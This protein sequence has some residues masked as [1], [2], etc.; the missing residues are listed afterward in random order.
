MLNKK[1]FENIRAE[2]KEFEEKRELTIQNSRD[3][4]ALS[5]QCVYAVHRGDM[6]AAE[7]T[8]PQMKS[9]LKKLDQ[10]EDYETSMAWVAFQEYAEAFCFFELVKSK[11]IPTV[12][13]VGIPVHAYLAG[14]CDLSGEVMRKA[15]HDVIKKDYDS[16]M[17]WKDVV[18]ELYGVFLQFDLRNGELR[19]KSDQIKWNLNKLEDMV[20]T[21]KTGARI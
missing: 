11:K 14:L 17:Q 4:I 7:A 13:E 12:K 16:V 6:K 5:K 10:A 9:L 15:V 18:E 20:F 2:L 19:K 3:V 21:L 8:L 1:D